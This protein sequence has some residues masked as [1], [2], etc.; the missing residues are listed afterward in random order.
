MRKVSPSVF[1]K[2]PPRNAAMDCIG[3]IAAAADLDF[4]TRLN[5]DCAD[6][7]VSRQSHL[8]RNALLL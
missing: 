7:T 3:V 2:R 8:E 1:S 6:Y 4:D 5:P